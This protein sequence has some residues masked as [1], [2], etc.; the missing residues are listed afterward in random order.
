M[1]S[2][3]SMR[4]SIEFR[5]AGYADIVEV[6]RNMRPSDKRELYAYDPTEN[7]EKLARNL[8]A[9]ERYHW[10]ASSGWRPIVILS[11]IETAPTLWQVGM[12]ATEEW[13]R[14]SL[15]CTLFFRHE[16]YPMLEKAGCN[17]AEC[18]SYIHHATA[19][20]WLEVL[21]AERECV[22]NDVG[23]HRDIYIQYAWTRTAF[24]T[25]KT[26]DKMSLFC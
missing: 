12:F 10:V 16:I 24:E 20:K 3:T 26:I 25:K 11:A 15:G 13:P 23:I 19:H 18:R 14:V 21:G 17:R 2:W 22:L 7:P 9:H 5:S 8:A 1:Q 6:A 4:S